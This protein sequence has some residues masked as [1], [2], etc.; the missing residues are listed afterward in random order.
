MALFDSPNDIQ[1][2]GQI[3][4]FKRTSNETYIGRIV[5]ERGDG[6]YMDNMF[7]KYTVELIGWGQKLYNV[8]VRVPEAG[9]NGA[10]YYASYKVNDVVILQAKEGQLDE[11]IIVGSTRLNGDFQ[12]LEVEGQGQVHGEHYVGPRQRIAASNPPA[13]HP[14][15][16][17]KIDSNFYIGGVNNARQSFED[18][19]ELGTLEE[20]LDKQPIPGL[21]KYSTKEGVDVNYAYG[22]ILHMTDGNLVL[23]SSGNQQ[24]KCTKYLEQAER[25][26]RIASYINRLGSFTQTN[27]LRSEEIEQASQ[28]PEVDL[29]RPLGDTNVVSISNTTPLFSSVE[30]QAASIPNEELR[31]V[32]ETQ[33][34]SA[35]TDVI[36]RLA[37]ASSEIDDID[38]IFNTA[39][40]TSLSTSGSYG[41][42]ILSSSDFRARKHREL[43]EIARNQAEECNSTGAAYQY[44]SLLMNNN[45]TKAVQI[46][47]GNSPTQTVANVNP[48]NFSS[49]NGGQAKPATEQRPAHPTNFDSRT[50]T[51]KYLVMHHSVSTME[52][53]TRDFQTPNYRASAQYGID[54]DGTVVQF[55]PDTQ[56]AY[57]VKSQN[58]GKI[59]IEIVATRPAHGMTTEQ[60]ESLIKLSRYIVSTYNIPLENIRGHNEF[61][62]T[63][64]PTWVFPTSSALRSWVN[65]YLSD[66]N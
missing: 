56:V 4:T 63:E 1:W 42:A 27:N 43:S 39:E 5:D 14:A 22:G 60:E 19:T 47:S 44:S 46:N 10:G 48:N 15:R 12:K 40:N 41:T 29:S 53:M 6:N 62:N 52:T 23:L 65:T 36:N 3:D 54:R 34:R 51:I 66:L 8:K 28:A 45:T 50:H 25:H 61:M 30:G 13:I 32:G 35:G 20:S 55:V 2:N 7:Q 31:E 37:N 11:A 18:P 38:G 24:N 16:A 57:H 9:Y 64:C 58:T 59:G 21:L 26:A 49:R 33:S 17:T